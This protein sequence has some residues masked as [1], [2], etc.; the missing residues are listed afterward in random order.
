MAACPTRSSGGAIINVATY[1]V[2]VCLKLH[3]TEGAT[4]YN[5]A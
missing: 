5:A 4:I 2:N 3:S 1:L